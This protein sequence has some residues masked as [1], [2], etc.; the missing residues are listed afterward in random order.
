MKIRAKVVESEFL[1]RQFE[2]DCGKGTQMISW[3]AN[4]AC[5]RF[6]QEHYPKGIYVPNLLTKEDPEAVP[7]PRSRIKDVCDD[8]ELVIV[9]LKDRNRK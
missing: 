3:L 6:G 4:T 9:H 8:G 7:H 2:I 5:L 1:D